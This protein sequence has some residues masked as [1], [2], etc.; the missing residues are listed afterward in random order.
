[1]FKRGVLNE[2]QIRCIN[3]CDVVENMAHLFFEC[4]TSVGVWQR[5]L[6]WLKFSAAMHNKLIILYRTQINLQVDHAG[7]KRGRRFAALFGLHVF[8]CYGK[9]VTRRLLKNNG[10]RDLDIEE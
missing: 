10:E 9:V 5:I 7:A 8:G 4:P 1:M 2:S 6:A 3:G